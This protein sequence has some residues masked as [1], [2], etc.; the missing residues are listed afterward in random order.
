MNRH[1]KL[2]YLILAGDLTWLGAI[3]FLPS[4][5]GTELPTHVGGFRLWTSALVALVAWAGLYLSKDLEGFRGGWRFPH[6]CAQVTVGVLYLA[7]LLSGIAAISGTLYSSATLL[8]L[9]CLS[10]LGFVSIR[11]LAWGAVIVRARRHPKRRVVIL[12]SGRIVRELTFK[13]SRHPEMGMEVAGVLFPSD[14]EHALRD[15]KLPAGAMS[16]RTLD[17]L[18]IIKE[19]NVQELIVIEP[20]PPGMESEKLI[21][22][23]GNAGVAVHLVPQ[24]YELYLSKAKLTELEGVP[25]LSLEEQS[26]PA[27]GLEVKRAMDIA[28]SLALLIIASPL[29]L[30]S[31]AALYLLKGRAIRRELRCGKHGCLFW[32][33]RLNVDRDDPNLRAGERFL[34]QFSLTELL[35]LWNVLRGEMSLVGPRPESPDRVKHYSEWQRQRLAVL[36]GL[37]GLAQVNGLREQHS[38]EAKASF[39]LQYI[40]HWSLFLDLS[41]LFQTGWTFFVRLME[42]WLRSS[43]KSSCESELSIAMVANANSAQS[44]AD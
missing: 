18:G 11:C 20:L 2:R 1:R 26:Q 24:R 19:R 27:L 10:P 35:Q 9:G 7:V 38:S 29:L 42:P 21:S 44:G 6:I 14:T 25:L 34:A 8:N 37:T 33:Y 23:C 17:I 13:I 22:S 30:V 3:V 16:I 41:L 28:G 4:W 31:A 39:D 32:M 12:G 5:L 36:P 40:L 15:S 43:S